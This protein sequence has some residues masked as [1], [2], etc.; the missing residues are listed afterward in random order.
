MLRVVPVEG[1]QFRD[2]TH[3][4]AETLVD[5]GGSQRLRTVAGQPS[6]SCRRGKQ[7]RRK[8]LLARSG[9]C[10]GLFQQGLCGVCI[11]HGG[12]LDEERRQS[13]AGREAAERIARLR[14]RHVERV[15]LGDADMG[16]GLAL[17]HLGLSTRNDL[18]PTVQAC[19]LAR[20]EATSSAIR[21]WASCR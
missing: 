9:L 10:N 11:T 15:D 18:E 13:L 5:V 21:G 20:T 19:Q 12:F 1:L 6:I 16:E 4:G 14:E 2:V 3:A 7:N 8:S 17:I